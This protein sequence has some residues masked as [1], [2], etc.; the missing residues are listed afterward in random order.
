MSKFKLKQQIFINEE[1]HTVT[2]V[3]IVEE[4]FNNA[5]YYPI[6][7]RF[8]GKA[9]L[10]EGDTDNIK[11]ATKIAECKME[12]Q[13]HKFLKSEAKDEIRKLKQKLNEAKLTVVKENKI[14]NKI[15]KHI[16]DIVEEM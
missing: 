8:V 4:Y 10:K 12:R 15:T 11:V 5:I 3:G 9:V 7:K 1:K 14:I 16:T 2:V 6:T 13:Y